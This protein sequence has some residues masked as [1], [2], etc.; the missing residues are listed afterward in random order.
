[1]SDVKF[2]VDGEKLLIKEINSKKDFESFYKNI[3]IKKVYFYQKSWFW[4]SNGFASILIIFG[5]LF[6]NTNGLSL[7]HI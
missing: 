3:K 7:I 2:E 6:F 5:F 1:M 4:T